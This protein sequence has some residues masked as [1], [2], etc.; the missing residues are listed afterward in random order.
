MVIAA[1][2]AAPTLSS[3]RRLIW[4]PGMEGPTMTQLFAAEDLA[5]AEFAKR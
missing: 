1:P 4:P 2:A 5:P 3:C